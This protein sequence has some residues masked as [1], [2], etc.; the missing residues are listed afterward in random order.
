MATIFDYFEHKTSE[1][2][3]KDAPILVGGD[4]NLEYRLEVTSKM[5]REPEFDT[6][7]KKS[8]LILLKSKE[9]TSTS[10]KVKHINDVFFIREKQ[11]NLIINN[12]FVLRPKLALQHRIGNLIIS[13]EQEVDRLRAATVTDHWAIGCIVTLSLTN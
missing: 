4:A 7:L 13:R 3:L 9:S 1:L 11:A 10:E 5:Q 2:K 8:N 12:V 6:T